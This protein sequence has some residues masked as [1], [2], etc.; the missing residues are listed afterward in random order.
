MAVDPARNSTLP[1]GS[2]CTLTL[3]AE[4]VISEHARQ[5]AEAE[6]H[7]AYD[8]SFPIRNCDELHRA[9][10]SY[11]RAPKSERARLRRFIARRRRELG[12]DKELPSTW[13]A[14]EHG[15]HGHVVV[16]SVKH[17]VEPDAE[18]SFRMK[19]DLP[20]RRKKSGDLK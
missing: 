3:V 5:E 15:R 12:C 17:K 8:H 18:P 13:Y 14:G 2:Q 6:G 4:K 7:T 19:P 10:Q 11:G 9:I 20:K 16:K 1:I